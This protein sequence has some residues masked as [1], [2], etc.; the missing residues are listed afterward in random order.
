VGIDQTD[1]VAPRGP[2]GD[3][4]PVEQVCTVARLASA[5]PD[6]Q[7]V[8][9]KVAVVQMVTDPQ[10]IGIVGH[11]EHV[12]HPGREPGGEQAGGS[13]WGQAGGEGGSQ[14]LVVQQVV[15]EAAGSKPVHRRGRQGGDILAGDTDRRDLVRGPGKPRQMP[16]NPVQRQDLAAV[17]RGTG[18]DQRHRPGLTPQRLQHLRLPGQCEH[19]VG[20]F[21][22]GRLEK[23]LATVAQPNATGIGVGEP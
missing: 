20:V 12:V 11:G 9:S 8:G 18:A 5:P 6:E 23:G 14:P 10:C 16:L 2:E 17:A 19:G 15:N 22:A 21:R 4:V 13:G 7:V 1:P 3:P